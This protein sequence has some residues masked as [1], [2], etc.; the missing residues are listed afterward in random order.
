MNL[1]SFLPDTHGFH[2]DLG[3]VKL[4][5]L[6][7]RDSDHSTIQSESVMLLGVCVLG[8]CA[9]HEQWIT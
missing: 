1:Q 6:I 2:S 3:P 5:R 8:N 7:R 9:V 4:I